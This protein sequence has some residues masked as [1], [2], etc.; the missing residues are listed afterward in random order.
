MQGSV[1]RRWW[2]YFNPVNIGRELVLGWTRSELTLFLVLIGLQLLV[3]ALGLKSGVS[4][5]WFGLTTGILNIITVVLVAKGRITNY[6][7]G[8]IYAAMYLPL[9]LQSHLFGEVTLACFWIVM[10]IIGVA[11]WLGFMQ[12]DKTDRADQQAVIITKY[13]T[14]RQ[15]LWVLP[16]F[17]LLLAIA[18]WILTQA[19]SRQPY[20]DG[21][22]TAISMGA[23]I[24]QTTK[25]AEAWYAWLLVDLVEIV[26]WTR[27]WTGHADPS[28]FAMLGM[29][30]ALTVNAIYGIVQWRRLVRRR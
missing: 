3:W 23:Q 1:W 19:G 25:Y 20:L 21:A 28:A 5:D 12:P 22:T 26:L 27:A 15:W 17:L 2:R 16:V 4:P 8:L 6:F 7:W 13:L 14:P 11:A 10:Q 9:A 29:N 18:G 24:L 30:I